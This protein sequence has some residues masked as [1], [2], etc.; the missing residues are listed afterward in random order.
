M[1][2][3]A[4]IIHRMYLRTGVFSL[5]LLLASRLLGLARES[6]QAAAF[7]ASGMGDVVIVM[8]TLPDLLV[9]ILVSGAL[10]YVLLPAWAQQGRPALAAAQQKIAWWLLGSGV[11]LGAAVWL[12]RHALMRV[13]AP[14]LSI[15]MAAI[16]AASFG[17]SAAVLPMAMLAALWSTRLQHERDFVGMYA[18]NLVVNLLLVAGLLGVAYL[19]AGSGLSASQTITVLGCCLL[20]AM[21]GRLTWLAWR[22]PVRQVA[23]QPVQAVALPAARIWV[24]AALSSALVLMMPLVARSMVSQSGE[25]A[26]ASFNYAWKLVELPLL[27]AVQLIASLAFPA[28]AS[29]AVHSPERLQA[30][31]V[32]FALAWALACAAVAVVATFA[33]PLASLLFGWGSMTASSLDII[34]R[35]GAIGVWSLLPQ[36]LIAVLLTVMAI[37]GRMRFAVFA[38]AAAMVGLMLFGWSGVAATQGQSV[39]WALNVALALVAAGLVVSERKYIAGALPV[40][41]LLPPLLVC[42]LLLSL[43]PLWAGAGLLTS[44]LL[45]FAYGLLVLASAAVSSPAL[46]HLVSLKLG[47]RAR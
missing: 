5:G 33:G 45:A 36:A 4:L 44:G 34:A 11:V 31:Q 16:S 12:G 6:A 23:Q 7:G 41:S 40:V 10:A 1:L 29:T 38:Y 19:V 42:V 8:F 46:R 22:L 43:K 47:Q 20:L 17:W 13:L 27:L 3:S 18:G 35:W 39:M 26:L 32:A 37:T 14:G 24:W 9:G 21:A 15:E 28:L 25:G 30:M 2:L